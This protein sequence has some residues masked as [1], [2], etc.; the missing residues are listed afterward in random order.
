MFIA[1]RT[2]RG[3]GGLVLYWK[4]TIDAIVECINNNKENEWR[5]TGFYSET[6]TQKGLNH[7]IYLEV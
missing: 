4:S 5:F 7:G 6:K 3:G 1:P 2:N